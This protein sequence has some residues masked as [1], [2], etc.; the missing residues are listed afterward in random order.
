MADTMWTHMSG[1]RHTNS[2]KT[3]PITL[4]LESD[5]KVMAKTMKSP[6]LDF[7]WPHTWLDSV[8]DVWAGQIRFCFAN[9][10]VEQFGSKIPSQPAQLRNFRSPKGSENLAWGGK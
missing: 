7:V 8:G 4:K 9:G 3:N 1:L 6:K 2:F 10:L 5:V